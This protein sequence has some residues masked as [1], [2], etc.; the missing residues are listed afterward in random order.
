MAR[1]PAV[2]RWAPGGG[3]VSE[4]TMRAAALWYAA[5][6]F[7]VFPC[8]PQAKEP[9]TRHGFKDA[10]TDEVRVAAWWRQWPDAN[11]GIPTGTASGLVA[12]DIDPRNG[13]DDS[14]DELRSKHGRFPDTA[15]QMTG[16][17]GRHIIFRNPGVRMPKTLAPG[18]DLKGDGGYIVVAPSIHPSGNRYEWDGIDGENA[19]LKPAD[20]PAWLLE[21]ARDRRGSARAAVATD[22]VKWR[23]GER[24]TKLTSLAGSLRRRGLALEAIE[25]ELLRENHRRCDP[26]LESPEVRRIA[27]SIMRYSANGAGFGENPNLTVFIPPGYANAFDAFLDVVR[28]TADLPEFLVLLFHVERSLGYGKP[29]D[30]TSLSQMV[31]GIP[32]K[33]LNAWV[34]RGCGLKKAA[35]IRANRA[36]ASQKRQLLFI[37]QRKSPA[38]GNEA[39]EYEVNWPMLTQYI[40][41]RRQQPLAT[42]V[43]PRYKAL[44]PARHTHNHCQRR[45]SR[46]RQCSDCCRPRHSPQQGSKIASK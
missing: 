32:S 31:D 20:A 16:G 14:L 43:S 33:K 8:K 22:A 45:S 25:R 5:H 19:L 29:S 26:P 42:L 1:I 37:R 17:G 2:R 23:P 9:L 21:R 34:R 46:Q 41:E 44:V 27:S 40:A 36:L 28:F 39:T 7:P 4:Q 24:N 6:G 13:G 35:I 18:I 3:A 30:R 11:I 10:T 15:E 38:L 12:V